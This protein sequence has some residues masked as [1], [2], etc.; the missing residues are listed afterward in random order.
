MSRMFFFGF[1]YVASF[2]AKRLREE[3]WEMAG[4]TRTKD[5]VNAMWEQGVEPHVWD[6]EAPM[7]APMRVMKGV[8]HV[9]HSIPP[10]PEGDRVLMHHHKLLAAITPQLKWYGFI[11]SISVYGDTHD[12]LADEEFEPNPS[13]PRAKMRLRSER[14][15]QKL[16]KKSNLPIHIFRPGGIYGPGR[17]ILG[18]VAAGRGRLIHKEGHQV[19]RI[20]VED[21]AS[22]LH[23]SLMN[24]APGSIY[25]VVD[26]LPCGPEEPV[27]MAFDLLGRPRPAVQTFEEAEENMPAGLKTFY[28]ENRRVS[29]ARIKSDLGVVL[30]YPTY[31]EGF[32]A[33]KEAL[34][35]RAEAS[36]APSS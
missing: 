2:L 14:N 21:L 16:N 34:D 28:V 35:D 10:T 22:V 7:E 23:A 5:K 12:E 25:N 8:T 4:T 6:G 19:S 32:E 36:V 18:H 9:L 3:G 27:A 15:H 11:S 24:P 17:S 13:L 26:D 29:N 31:K 20:H 30:K 33:L 1:G